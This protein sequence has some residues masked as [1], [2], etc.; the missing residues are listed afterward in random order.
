MNR[1]VRRFCGAF[2]RRT[3]NRLSSTPTSS[4]SAKCLG[5]MTHLP[6]RYRAVL[7]VAI[8]IAC[9]GQ[10]AAVNKCLAA[11]GAITFQD[12]ACPLSS[13]SSNA[14]RTGEP[15]TRSTTSLP[16]TPTPNSA[17]TISAKCAT[18]WPNDFRMRAFCEKQQGNALQSLG[19]PVNA[20]PRE[21][22]TIRTKCE[23]DWPNDFRMRAFCETQQTNALQS[24]SKPLNAGPNEAQTIRTKCARD[25]PDDYRMRAFCENKQLEGLRQLQR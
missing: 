4:D 1:I 19:Q 5:A 3:K 6:A 13:K 12:A 24:L 14:V 9:C 16:A 18:D 22:D 23:R 2:V 10:A 15:P 20:A 7:L 21:A 17:G 25:W 11:N 8:G